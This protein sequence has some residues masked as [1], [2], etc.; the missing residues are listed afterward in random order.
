MAGTASSATSAKRT[1]TNQASTSQASTAI[2]RT[3]TLYFKSIFK[4]FATI[5]DLV[6]ADDPQK[7]AIES[8]P[9]PFF[10]SFMSWYKH[11]SGRSF[12]FLEPKLSY[13][14]MRFSNMDA[15]DV[16]PNL[17]VNSANC[18]FTYMRAIKG[19]TSLP[20]FVKLTSLSSRVDN[21][22]IDNVNAILLMTIC[23]NQLSEKHIMRFYD[24]FLTYYPI[25]SSQWSLPENDNMTMWPQRAQPSYARASLMETIIG[26]PLKSVQS[27]MFN[28]VIIAFQSFFIN[29]IVALGVQHGVVHNDLHLGNLFYEPK[30]KTIKMIDYGRMYVGAAAQRPEIVEMIQYELFK[31]A[32]PHESI[33]SYE[34]LINEHGSKGL[35]NTDANP[36]V[37][38]MDAITL[39]ANMFRLFCSHSKSFMHTFEDMIMFTSNDDIKVASTDASVLLQLYCNTDDSYKKHPSPDFIR[40]VKIM[41]EGLLL[42]ALLVNSRAPEATKHY[43]YTSFQFRK[44]IDEFDKF[45]DVLDKTFGD[46]Q[47]TDMVLYDDFMSRTVLLSQMTWRANMMAGGALSTSA[48]R[49]ASRFT[50][51]SASRL[52]RPVLR[53]VAKEK[54]LFNPIKE[55]APPS[56][57][58]GHS[59]KPTH[60]QMMASL[61]AIANK[62]IGENGVRLTW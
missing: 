42:L 25:N 53:T 2:V 21:P 15:I 44:N 6:Y 43:L 62:D 8:Q 19:G 47:M 60:S 30:T 33:K 1:P 34:A 20:L 45:I 3:T 31:Y 4:E 26:I 29:T 40:F 56:V 48:R 22:V 54:P 50:A 52:G 18:K 11:Y 35:Y 46:L 17:I 16:S 37:C 55:W 28:D 27:P 41:N 36:K 14:I 59:R 57:R 61:E 24:S 49:Y 23:R 10:K 58:S 51:A 5:F 39:C 32:M 38:I 13:I 12:G 9:I 7:H